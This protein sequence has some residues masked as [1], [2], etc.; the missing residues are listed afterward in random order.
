LKKKKSEIICSENADRKGRLLPLFSLFNKKSLILLLLI[1]IPILVFAD[2]EGPNSPASGAVDT[3]FGSITWT[4]P[5]NITANDTSRATLNAA[6]SDSYYLKGTDF[7]F[8]IPSGATIDGIILEIDKFATYASSIKDVRVRIVKSD[9]TIGTTD[10]A[11]TSTFW[12][13][14]EAAKTYGSSSDLWGETWTY[15]DINDVDFGA[16]L[17]ADCPFC[18]FGPVP[19]SVDNFRI[20][21]YYTLGSTSYYVMSSSNY[22]MERDSLNN[23]GLRSTSPNYIQESTVGEVGTGKSDSSNYSLRAGYQQM[24]EVYLAVSAISDV[25]MSPNLGGITGGTSDGT[26]QF[27][28]TTDSSS[29]Y[30]VAIQTDSNNGMEGETTSSVIPY[31]DES[32]PYV[33]DYSF[34]TAPTNSAAFAYTIN[35]STTGEIVQAFRNNGSNA[36]NTGSTETDDNCW[37]G[38]TTTSRT[39]INR[40]S[41][42]T[43]GATSTLS[44]RVIISADPQP[45]LIEDIYTSTTTLTVLAL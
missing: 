43:T 19:A 17:S 9:G 22:K 23:A 39:I 18:E 7:G 29:G 24:G 8:S 30:T 42:A 36:C 21:V 1:L 28:V 6:Q 33:P 5:G 27:T 40:T 34:T 31:L 26:T 35:A 20:T 44:Y 4:N 41:A 32:S 16:V 37:I 2:T 14:S 11:D 38:A 10:K 3:S 25:V 45:I 15:S 13:T 12:P